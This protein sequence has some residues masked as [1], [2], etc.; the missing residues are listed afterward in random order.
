M[1]G[2]TLDTPKAIGG[3]S[4]IE[5]SIEIDIPQY[6]TVDEAESEINFQFPEVRS[7]A[8]DELHIPLRAVVRSFTSM[9]FANRISAKHLNY[10]RGRL[11]WLVKL[12][13]EYNQGIDLQPGEDIYYSRYVRFQLVQAISG[14]GYQ[15]KDAQ[16]KVRIPGIYEL[17]AALQRT[18]EPELNYY[19]SCIQD[20]VIVFDALQELY[21]PGL[22][23]RGVTSLGVP[24]GFRVVQSYYQ[25]RK[26]LFGF[27]QSFH[28]ELHYIATLG[29]DFAVVQF[30][31]VMSRWMG[32]ANRKIAELF[33][34]PAD[35]VLQSR[36]LTAGEKYV[37]LGLGGPKYLQHDGGSI[38]LHSGRSKGS[39]L[40]T[41]GRIMIDVSRGALTGHH[42][43]SGMDDATQALLEITGR[44]KRYKNEQK[45][46][47]DDQSVP[48]NPDTIFIMSTVPRQ[49]LCVTWPALVGF[50]FTTKS[51]CTCLVGGLKHIRFNDSA[52]DELVLDPMRKRLIRALVRFGGKEEQIEDIIDGKSGGSIFLLHG[53]SGVGKTLTAE[54]I[55]EVLH[56]PLYYV[57]MGELGTDPAT[58][59]QRLGEILE[60]CSG[61]G[62][63][64]LI[65]EADVFL[66]KR[67]SS[68]ILRNAMTCVML[69]LLEYHQG[70][71]FLTSNRVTEFD[72]ALES[73]VT[74]ALRYTELTASARIQVGDFV[75]LLCFSLSCCSFDSNVCYVLQ[76]CAI[77]L[78]ASFSILFFLGV[79]EYVGPSVLPHWEYRLRESRKT[80]PEWPSDK[81][82]REA[83]CSSVPGRQDATGPSL[84]GRDGCVYQYGAPGN[85][86]R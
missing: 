42:A 66:E 71:L 9:K 18:F 79:E 28:V 4:A 7:D 2:D 52:F 5:K 15:T 54:A 70:I 32:E 12:V 65:D 14:L 64:T 78:N 13:E 25:E 69:R 26:S 19:R 41:T 80:H 48:S 24:A 60:L 29:T 73:R 59:E 6:F 35:E 67:V 44:Y 30:E 17:Q 38:I 39:A 62:A 23:V 81:E 37:E 68:D 50:S 72:P 33:Y 61:W 86:A 76:Y 63:L 49:L 83:G 75:I 11:A 3:G 47:M 22:I 16:M 46:M 77:A 43:T 40:P 84:F 55:A 74:V 1:L 8:I 27:E 45:S 31:A 82:L 51:W 58:M 85:A 56:K 34:A 21:Q 20:G 36:F 10:I 57:T 53:P